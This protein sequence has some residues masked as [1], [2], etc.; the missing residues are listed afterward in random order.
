MRTPQENAEN[1]DN[2]VLSITLTNLKGRLIISGTHDD[3]VH[4]Q[5]NFTKALV[6]ADKQFVMLYTTETIIYM[7]IPECTYSLKV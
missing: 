4:P 1:Y 5:N 3:N 2:T 7:E 6:Q